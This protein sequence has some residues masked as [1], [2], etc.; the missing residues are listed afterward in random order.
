MTA[1][2][3]TVRRLMILDGISGVPLGKELCEAF[4]ANGYVTDY[5][6]FSELRKKTAC[7][8]RAGFWKAYNRIFEQQAFYHFPKVPDQEL[9]SLMD[10]TR[11]DIVLVIGFSYRFID[12]GL[13]KRLQGQY[14]FSLFLYDTDSC[15]FYA[16]RREFL[17]FIERELPVYDRI[18]SFS[19]VT[20]TLFSD[21]LK[22]KADFLPFG[23]KPISLPTQT[24]KTPE[25][26]FVGSGDLRRVL[27]LEK[28]RDHL[29]VYGARWERNF[30][31][32]SEELLSRVVDQEVWGTA[33][34]QL[35]NSAKIV[36]NITRTDFYGAGTG[37]NLRI[38][39]ALAAGCF[40]LTDYTDEIAELFEIGEEIEAFRSPAELASKVRYYL[41]NDAERERI[42]RNGHEKF[43]QACTWDARVKTMSGLMLEE[44]KS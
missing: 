22:L 6:A 38:F 19:R 12:P 13:L 39:E 3:A 14:R 41:E 17:Y 21:T 40:L 9:V 1:R 28:I 27:L 5:C 29:T 7:S 2:P 11:P 43:L 20:A 34:H 24:R 30:P 23:A 37:V 32:M 33:L 10:R 44:S 4:A 36:L 42:A 8:L 26:L 16:K 25:V 35:L 31:L 15:N 18:F